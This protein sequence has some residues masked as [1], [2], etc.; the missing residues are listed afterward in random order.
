M[1]VDIHIEFSKEGHGISAI[2]IIYAQMI[3]DVIPHAGGSTTV[4]FV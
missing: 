2:L 4:D 1:S 3:A